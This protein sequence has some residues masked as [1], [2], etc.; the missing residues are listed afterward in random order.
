MGPFHIRS[1][2][3]NRY[4][5]GVFLVQQ[6]IIQTVV[7]PINPDTFGLT[8]PHEHIFTDLRGPQATGYAYGTPSMVVATM[9]PFLKEISSLGVNS[10]VECSTIGVGRN[11]TI[12]KEV[13][14]ATGLNIVAP[15]GVYRETYV[16]EDL[17]DKSIHELAD[18][19][20]KDIS[21]GMDGTDIKA[22]FI[23]MAVSDEGVSALEAKNL[24]AA[25]ITARRTGAAVACHTIGGRLAFEVMD[26]LTSF[27]MDL[28]R[29]I[30][31]HA[32]SESDFS[33]LL[34]AA[35]RGVIISIDAI[36][37]GWAPDDAMLA[38][39]INLIAAGYSHQILLSHDAGWYDPSQP[40][41]HPQPEGI[42]GYSALF[43]SF[44]PQL[45]SSGIDGETIA[46]ITI[47]N[48]ATVFTLS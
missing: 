11:P 24:Q 37:S 23:K 33:Y 9:A 10:L 36:G 38:A 21:E 14:L 8:L 7:S 39:T 27:G 3:C 32:Q 12:L 13:S 26:L 25:V 42:R 40:D 47:E 46:R 2:G 30:W 41:G 28:G 1:N 45:Q 43:T 5:F 31:T 4:H 34:K 18:M 20:V 6:G 22:G 44:L 17:K 48:P 35:Q 19:W 15:T 16:P 29:F